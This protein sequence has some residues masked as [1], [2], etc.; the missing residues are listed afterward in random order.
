VSSHPR[1]RWVLYCH[2]CLCSC[3]PEH[4]QKPE[5][6]P[7]HA[8]YRRK[9]RCQMLIVHLPPCP[10]HCV[11]PLPQRSAHAQEAVCICTAV[12]WAVLPPGQHRKAGPKETTAE[13]LPS[14]VLEYGGTSPV[15]RLLSGGCSSNLLQHT[16][17]GQHP[18]TP[19][20]CSAGSH[21]RPEN[22][23]HS[24]NTS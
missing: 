12:P 11:T 16:V 10:L 24:C 14:W 4:A 13:T 5:H 19:S 7:R 3:T 6:V 22:V 18:T 2:C 20:G 23:T 9:C 15:P 8:S 17:Q 1:F 21:S